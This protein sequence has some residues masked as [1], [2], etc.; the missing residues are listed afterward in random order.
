MGGEER[1]ISRVAH[2]LLLKY[3]FPG[4]VRELMNVLQRAVILSPGSQVRK[5]DLP[6]Q[7]RWPGEADSNEPDLGGRTLP[8][9][10]EEIE[11]RAIR[12]ALAEE[13]NVKARAARML[14]LP[15]RV[16]R[17]KLKKYGIDPTKSS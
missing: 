4:N 11:R 12:K 14:G 3:A 1:T 16:L 15:E 8:E 6:E 9:L 2:D 5:D 17:Y 7:I 13:G 10:V